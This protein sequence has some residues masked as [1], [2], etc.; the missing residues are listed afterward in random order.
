MSVKTQKRM[1]PLEQHIDTLENRLKILRED[2]EVLD[3]ENV[4][5]EILNYLLDEEN[6]FEL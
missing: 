1:G 4:K 5:K 3:S 6:E 2:P